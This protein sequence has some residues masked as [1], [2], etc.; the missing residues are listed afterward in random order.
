MV[1]GEASINQ[2]NNLDPKTISKTYPEGTSSYSACFQ[3]FQKYKYMRQPVIIRMKKVKEL[4][5]F[6]LK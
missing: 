1:K 4:S 6:H 2:R 5:N 3:I